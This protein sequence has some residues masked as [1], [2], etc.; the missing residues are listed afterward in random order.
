MS[1]KHVLIRKAEPKDWQIIQ[2]LNFG[3]YSHQTQFDPYLD[4]D[5]PFT[6]ESIKDYKDDVSNPKKCALIAEI[7]GKPVGYLVGE[8][9]KMSYRKL[10]LA[11]IN[12]MAVNEKYRCQG[13]GS[14]LMDQFRAWCYKNNIDRIKAVAYYQN[15]DTVKFY[16]KQGLKP[17]GIILEGKV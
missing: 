13:I 8:K 2:K 6:K 5:E 12:H 9:T 7:A 1:D 10:T 16:S 4:M 17:E 3:M 15:T 11:E 14:K